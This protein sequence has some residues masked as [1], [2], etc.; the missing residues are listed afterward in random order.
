MSRY[1]VNFAQGVAYNVS[2]TGAQLTISGINFPQVSGTYMPIVLNPG[3]FGATNTSGPEIVYVT[4]VNS[5]G[6]VATLSARAQEGSSL[7]SG[8]VVPWVAGPVVADFDVSNLT[9]TGTLSLNNGISASGSTTFN[10]GATVTSGI[11]VN[12]NSTFNNNLTVIGNETISGTVTAGGGTF[13]LSLI[14]I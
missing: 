14:H 7:A 4:S 2:G 3:Y 11:T 9:S 13:G 1:R 12:G 6:T 10:S 8:A 5:S